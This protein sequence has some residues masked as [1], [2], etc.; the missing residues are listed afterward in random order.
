MATCQIVEDRAIGPV[1]AVAMIDEP[2]ECRSHCRQF[3]DLASDIGDPLLRDRLD[4]GAGAAAVAIQVEQFPAFLDRE[5]E[6]ART[7]HEGQ[8][9]QIL[10]KL[11]MNID[12]DRNGMPGDR[13]GR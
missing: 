7:L 3:L 1:V 10:P 13:R 2:D 12:R 4:V 5:T 6:G 8:A 11:D 9:M